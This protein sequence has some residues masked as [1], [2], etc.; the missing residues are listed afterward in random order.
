MRSAEQPDLRDAM[1]QSGVH[2]DIVIFDSCRMMTF[3]VCSAFAGYADFLAGAERDSCGFR[4]S[5][6]L[7]MINYM[8]RL[9]PESVAC[10][11]AECGAAVSR[12][13]GDEDYVFSAI[14]LT[15]VSPL[16][17]A[18]E[19]LSGALCDQP[20]ADILRAGDRAEYLGER[21]ANEEYTDLVDLSSLAQELK[22]LLP[23]ETEN[24][25]DTIRQCVR[26]CVH[27]KE[28]LAQG[29][30]V[31]FRVIWIRLLNRRC[32]A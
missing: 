30:S 9:T 11:A 12:A 24:V 29:I 3:E 5:E 18:F 2:P 32:R 25:Q 15:S 28:T 13:V 4:H 20:I 23:Q 19:R 7:L 26:I 10:M 6:W 17:S 22:V 1:V 27:G 8:P 16:L 31:F 21:N 14:D